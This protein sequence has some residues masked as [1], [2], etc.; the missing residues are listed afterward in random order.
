MIMTAQVRGVTLPT[1]VSV[2]VE[3]KIHTRLNISAYVAKQRANVCLV[4]YCGQNFCVDEPILQLGEQVAWLVP[5]WLASPREGRKTKIGE[6]V[7]DAQTGEVL[8]SRERCRVL[9]QIAQALLEPSPSTP[10]TAPL[11]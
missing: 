4:L 8:E 7:V 1:D 11:A 9:Q 3:I 5:V 10:P 2:D 6:F